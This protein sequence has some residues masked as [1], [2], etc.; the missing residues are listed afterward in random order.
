MNQTTPLAAVESTSALAQSSWLSVVRAYQACTRKYEQMLA[1]FGLTLP[2]F[3]ALLAIERLG[4]QA[5]PKDIAEALWVTRGNITGVLE[6]LRRDGLIRIDPHPEDG[7]ARIAAL[8]PSGKRLLARA[9]QAAR[10][11]I[12]AQLAPFSAAE[13]EATRQT[14]Q[15]MAAHLETLDPAAIAQAADDAPRK[16]SP[17]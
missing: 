2:Q 7:R 9:Q 3:E 10:G 12:E 11:F 6:R 14:M 4:P 5:Q 8:K 13:M 15:R 16:D 17:R 1:E